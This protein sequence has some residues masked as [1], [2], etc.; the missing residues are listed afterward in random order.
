MASAVAAGRSV[1]EQQRPSAD[2][3]ALKPSGEQGSSRASTR[4]WL[5]L[6]CAEHEGAVRVLR[7]RNES[8]A[9]AAGLR[10]GD[11]IVRID[12]T[13]VADLAQLW[14]A[15]RAG[16]AAERVVQ[17]DIERGGQ[18]RTLK[19]Q[20]MDRSQVLRRARGI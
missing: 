11:R 13:A 14:K 16:G 6:N 2:P 3:V 8:P 20:S 15:L 19:L 4:A 1:T 18:A 9:E 5:G 10:A 7:V 12:G 17:L